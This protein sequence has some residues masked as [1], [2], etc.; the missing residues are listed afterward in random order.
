MQASRVRSPGSGR[1]ERVRLGA[2][3]PGPITRRLI[4]LY[5]QLARRGVA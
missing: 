1:Y 4:E 2:G 5:D 3:V